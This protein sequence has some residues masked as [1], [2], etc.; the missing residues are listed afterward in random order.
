MPS[1]VR[2]TPSPVG[3]RLAIVTRRSIGEML[4]DANA[5]RRLPCRR[6]GPCARPP[7]VG[8]NCPLSR[9]GA[10]PSPTIRGARPGACLVSPT[11]VHN[12]RH[13]KRPGRLL[14]LVCLVAACRANEAPKPPPAVRTAPVAAPTAI[15]EPVLGYIDESNQGV[16]ADGGVIRRRLIGE[17][18]TLNAVLQSGLPEQ[19]VLQ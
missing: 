17:P 8:V 4:W 11:V 13:V 12:V 15:P 16:P 19:Q 6:G 9:E 5:R 1:D 7:P 18:E 2:E 14:L 10:S 3:A